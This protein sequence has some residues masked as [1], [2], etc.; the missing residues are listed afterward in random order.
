MISACSAF[1]RV[2]PVNLVVDVGDVHNEVH[3]VA[4]VIFENATED[5]LGDI[6]AKNCKV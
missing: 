5:I 3:I 1:R 6:V 4:K 2:K